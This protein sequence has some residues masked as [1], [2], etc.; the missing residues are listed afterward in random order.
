[1]AALL[2]LA[3]GSACH[4]AAFDGPQPVSFNL[5]I[6]PI[7][8]SRCASC[9]HPGGSAPFSVLDYRSVRSH[10]RQILTVTRSGVMP[11]W[12]PAAGYGSFADERRLTPDEL[13][14]IAQWVAGG[15]VEGRPSDLPSPPQ[16][17][18]SWQLGW[19]DLVISLDR[20]YTLRADGPDVFRNFVIHV[21]VDRTR[22][23]RGFEFRS[24]A[25]NVIHHATILLDRS[26]ASRELDEQDDEPGFDGDVFSESTQNPSL[27]A[28]G[29]TPGKTPRLEP[30]DMGWELPQGSDMIVQLHMIPSGKPEAVQPSIAL[31]FASAPPSRLSI[32]FKLGTKSIDIPAGDPAYVVTDE[33]TTPVDLDVLSVYP[34]AHYLAHDMQ[35]FATLPDGSRKWLVWIKNWNFRWQDEYRYTTPLFLPRGSRIV[36][37]YTYDNSDANVQNPAHPPK[38]VRFGPAST[39]EMGDLW[40]RLLPR[41]A[42]D[43]RVIAADYQRRELAKNIAFAEGEVRE[44]PRDANW[45]SLLGTRYLQADRVDEGLRE[46]KAAVRLDPSHPQANN[47]LGAGLLRHG[48]PRAAVPYLRT[49]VRL[50]ANDASAQLNLAN[51]LQDTG[52]LDGAI[53]HFRRSLSLKPDVAEAHNNFGAA[54]AAHGRLDEA[55]EEFE[56][57]LRIAPQYAD[58]ER[59]LAQATRLRASRP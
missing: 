26:G 6:A 50:M 45:H 23:V 2:A 27:H 52:D 18:D 19:P 14:R 24:T 11:P 42:A 21:P 31:V 51:A 38:R 28:I 53:E 9:H 8:W 30:P 44:H 13:D 5:D 59:N 15:S 43:A 55:I 33:Y 41:S 3:A 39:N 16:F 32:D 29:W 25:Q 40:L 37:R 35:A 12:P 22:Y 17:T 48:E 34:H 10:S 1:V 4:G 46:L 56:T 47:N 7:L 57:A 36:M 58:A 20:P 49:A 54:L